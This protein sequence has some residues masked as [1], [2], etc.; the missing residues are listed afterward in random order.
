MTGVDDVA[1]A[2]L[3][4]MPAPGTFPAF[5]RIT[6]MNVQRANNGT[7]GAIVGVS[8][9]SVRILGTEYPGL[10]SCGSFLA[11]INAAG[12]DDFRGREVVVI[13]VGGRLMVLTTS[14]G[15]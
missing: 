13:S 14:G 6:N 1:A 8:P 15:S 4:A 10:M 9:L 11:E 12:T 5:G 2:I 3:A 7:T